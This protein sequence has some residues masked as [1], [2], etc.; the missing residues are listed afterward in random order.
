MTENSSSQIETSAKT[1]TSE[2]RRHGR[3][4][5]TAAVEALEAKSQ[6][7]MIGRTSDL[8]QGGCYIDAINSFSAGSIMKMRLTK[9]ACTVE[10]QA[11]V[12]YSSPGMGMGVKFKDPDQQVLWT[13]EKWMGGH[14]GETALQPVV[15]PASELSRARGT[16]DD[17]GID[18]LRELIMQLKRQ[19]LLRDAKCDS[20]LQKL[21][22]TWGLKSV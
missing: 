6:T 5:F 8:S 15:P 13:L 22:R 11:E 1:V 18:V 14:G 19:G 9:D 2:R 16:S 10:T 21:N 17:E 20:M 12:V 3:H 7:R 4:S